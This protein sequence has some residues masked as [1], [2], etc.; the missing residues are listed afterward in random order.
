MKIKLDEKQRNLLYA[1]LEKEFDAVEM[2][3]EE[4]DSIVGGNSV[5]LPKQPRIPISTRLSGK[6]IIIVCNR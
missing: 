5:S 3:K 4:L 6:K 2:S 1:E